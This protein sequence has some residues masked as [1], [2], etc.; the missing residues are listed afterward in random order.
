MVRSSDVG[1][2]IASLASIPNLA[3][4]RQPSDQP[5]QEWNQPDG[6]RPSQKP[7]AGT[8]ADP[9]AAAGSMAQGADFSPPSDGRSGKG[10]GQAAAAAAATKTIQ[11]YFY[12]PSN[13][14]AVQ[15]LAASYGTGEVAG[16]A[17]PASALPNEVDLSGADEDSHRGEPSFPQPMAKIGR[18]GSTGAVGGGAGDGRSLQHRFSHAASSAGDQGVGQAQQGHRQVQSR[19]QGVGLAAESVGS[20][21][22]EQA[23]TDQETV[24]KLHERL[25]EAKA[26]E[27]RLR[28]ELA[29]A[30]L[31]R[32]SME[33]MVGRVPYLTREPAVPPLPLSHLSYSLPRTKQHTYSKHTLV[34]FVFRGT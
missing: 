29:R 11:S 23:G 12:K 16:Q 9:L 17:R 34:L 13:S 26:L 18:S 14:T 5:D 22:G 32:G 27:T 3:G 19:A 4:A 2:L 31:E 28:K 1:L 30:N 7:V 33:T 10:G 20:T 21:D 24:E 25:R 15:N 6:L 8:P